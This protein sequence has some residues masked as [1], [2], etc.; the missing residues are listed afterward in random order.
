MCVQQLHGLELPGVNLLYCKH[1]CLSVHLLA[2]MSITLCLLTLTLCL[3]C[4]P[5]ML[6]SCGMLRSQCELHSCACHGHWGKVEEMQGA[7]K[8]KPHAEPLHHCLAVFGSA[9]SCF[10]SA[11]C[12]SNLAVRIHSVS[13][14]WSSRSFRTT[15]TT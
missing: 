13:L 9:A 11:V 15:S 6:L 3:L 1:V 5:C 8:Q 10:P 7:H 2:S 14:W 12:R 4:P